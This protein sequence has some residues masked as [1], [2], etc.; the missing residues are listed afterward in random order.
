MPKHYSY[1]LSNGKT[2]DLEG[3]EQPTDAEVE[4]IAKEQGVSLVPV[5][6]TK[7]PPKKPATPTAPTSYLDEAKSAMK[8]IAQ[9]ALPG[10]A[11]GIKDLPKTA[12]ET[13]QMVADYLTNP[14]EFMKSGLKLGM[15]VPGKIKDAYEA[16]TNPPH[17]EGEPTAQSSGKVIGKFLGEQTVPLA[18]GAEGLA[19]GVGKGMKIGGRYMENLGTRAAKG[20]GI[21]LIPGSRIVDL[22]VA[23]AVKKGGQL[24]QRGGMRLAPTKTVNAVPVE[25]TPSAPPVKDGVVVGETDTR[26]AL[27]PGRRIFDRPA[28]NDLANDPSFVRGVPADPAQKIPTPQP[29]RLGLPPKPETII[30]PPPAD[31]SG[32]TVTSAKKTDLPVRD[33]KTGRMKRVFTSESTTTTPSTPT[34]TPEKPAIQSRVQALTDKGHGAEEIADQLKDDPAFKGKSKNERIN[35][36]RE[37]RGGPSGQMPA[38]AKQAID[39]ALSK[40]KTAEEKRAYLLRAPNAVAY[41]YI[42]SRIGL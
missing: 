18:L 3:D 19:P 4:A 16:V 10:I 41:D 1:A 40:M 33:P 30:T 15:Q 6:D 42:K 26:P 9:G 2:L 14:G 22:A 31:T 28:G 34:S 36:V 27:P 32:I 8:G 29:Q 13:G 38:R 11:Q 39:Q 35:L 23:D 24:L 17:V 25:S 21:D 20:R 12:L 7:E 5:G 37:M